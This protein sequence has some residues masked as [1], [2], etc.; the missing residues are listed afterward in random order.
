M[1][2]SNVG[3]W[4]KV[5]IGGL[6]QR[7]SARNVARAELGAQKYTRR[8]QRDRRQALAGTDERPLVR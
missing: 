2:D 5:T 8:R 3:F 6:G 7:G 4:A 1:G